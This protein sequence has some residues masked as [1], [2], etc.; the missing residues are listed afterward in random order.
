MKCGNYAA[1]ETAAVVRGIEA[2]EPMKTPTTRLLILAALVSCFQ[3][4]CENSQPTTSST[5]RPYN[6]QKEQFQDPQQ[7][8][9]TSPGDA[10][11]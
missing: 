9:K 4:A 6:A 2:T 1:E 5:S 11:R 7:S 10:N 8:H 3:V